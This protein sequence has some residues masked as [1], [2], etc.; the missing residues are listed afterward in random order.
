M[1]SHAVKKTD[2][3][4][5]IVGGSYAHTA[6]KVEEPKKDELVDHI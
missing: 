2:D 5:V 3:G 1:T 4:L 6:H